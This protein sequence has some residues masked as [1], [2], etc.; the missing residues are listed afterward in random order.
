[1]KI[2]N[3]RGLLRI[4]QS[5]LLLWHILFFYALNSFRKLLKLLNWLNDH[6]LEVKCHVF[7][8]AQVF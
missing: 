6:Y 3:A 8:L 4:V 7:F 2:L 1:M 5:G